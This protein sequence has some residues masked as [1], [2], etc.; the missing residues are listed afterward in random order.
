M[1]VKIELDM[2]PE[3]FKKCLVPDDCQQEFIETTYDAYVD[4]LERLVGKQ[5]DP[6]NFTSINKESP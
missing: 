1:K 5:V 4:A 6:Y 2:T 3:E